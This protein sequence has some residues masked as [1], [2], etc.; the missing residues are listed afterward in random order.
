GHQLSTLN[1]VRIPDGVDDKDV[2]GRLLEE[3]GIEIGG[4]LGPMAGKVWRIGLM[5]EASSKRNV[6]LFLAALEECLTTAGVSVTAG[7]G[8][9]AASAAY[10][11]A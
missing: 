4:G 7:A 6:L 8:V 3:F 1:A 9:S 11:S 5:G 10:R 2:R